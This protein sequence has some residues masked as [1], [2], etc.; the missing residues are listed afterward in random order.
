MLYAKKSPIHPDIVA[1][2]GWLTTATNG[3]QPAQEPRLDS[4]Q[5][6]ACKVT[7]VTTVQRK[8]S[9]LMHKVTEVFTPKGSEMS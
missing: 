3:A 6:P 5:S 1:R 7:S 8:R 9:T 4:P 2:C